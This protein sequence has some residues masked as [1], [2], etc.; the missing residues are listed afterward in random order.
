VSALLARTVLGSVSPE[1]FLSLT[2]TLAITEWKLRFYGSVLGVAWTLVRP[3]AFFGVIYVV[4]V[5]I[6]DVGGAIP[7]Y[8]EYLLLALMLFGFFTEVTNGC[9]GALV[10]RGD[11]LRKIKVPYMIVPLS[12]TITALLNLGMSLVAATLFLTA[13]GTY[14]TIEWLALIPILLLLMLFALGVGLLL[15]A[16]YVRFR[17]IAPIWELVSQMLF[18]ASPVLYVA[19]MVPES[20]Q[21]PYLANPI[22]ALFTQMRHSIVDPSA[23][24]AAEAIGG[25]PRLLI[26]LAIVLGTFALGMW[27][28]N[29]EAPRVAERV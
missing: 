7:N 2:W 15:S 27:V 21:R 24:S 14:P 8:A 26:P 13:I 22:A 25:A 1:R 20:F 10:T 6:A 18:Y 17:D 3:F 16:L 11:L 5:E 28:F 9:V 19:T 12:V 23:S 4:F 29:R